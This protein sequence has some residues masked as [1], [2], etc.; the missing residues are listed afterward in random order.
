MAEVNKKKKLTKEQREALDNKIVL[1][2]SVALISTIFLMYLYRWQLAY[3]IGTRNVIL[4]LMWIGVAGVA[5]TVGL[6][7]FKKDKSFLNI[8]PYFAGMAF[9]FSLIAYNFLHH[10]GINTGTKINYSIIYTLLAI[11]L[12]ASYIYYGIKLKRK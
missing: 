6:Y 12:V 10:L 4:V 9:A 11:Y 7:W 8:T 3:P 1:A 5:V 2:T